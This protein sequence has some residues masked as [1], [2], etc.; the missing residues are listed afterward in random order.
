M[1]W[2][3]RYRPDDLCLRV[4]TICP[5][6]PGCVHNQLSSF[7]PYRPDGLDVFLWFPTVCPIYP[8]RIH[9]QW[10]LSLFLY[11]YRPDGQDVCLRVLTVPANQTV[12]IISYP[13]LISTQTRRPGWMF[14]SSDWLVYPSSFHNQW[15]LSYTDTDQYGQDV[16]LRV[17]TVLSVSITSYLCFIS[18]QTW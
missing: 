4:P 5:V 14:A 6:Y 15:S 17:L 7:Y 3:Y 9:N 11:L 10:L 1:S 12:S 18:M 16:C 13:R 8:S 2:L